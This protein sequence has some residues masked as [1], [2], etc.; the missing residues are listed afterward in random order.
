[1]KI[2]AIHSF[3]CPGVKDGNMQ[4]GQVAEVADN[5]AQSLIGSGQAQATDE[6][7]TPDEPEKAVEEEEKTKKKH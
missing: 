5:E 1:M 4:A 7:I 2:K 6:P 3:R